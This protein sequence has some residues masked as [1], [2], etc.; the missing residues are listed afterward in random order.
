MSDDDTSHLEELKLERERDRIYGKH[1]SHGPVRN[2]G[3]GMYRRVL[4]GLICVAVISLVAAV[5]TLMQ[6]VAILQTAQDAQRRDIDRLERRADTLEGRNLRGG[7]DA[8]DQ[9]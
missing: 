4:E 7:P 3:G 8:L 9:Q 5:W 2:D 1:Q 6:S